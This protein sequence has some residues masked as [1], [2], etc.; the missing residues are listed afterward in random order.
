VAG[1]GGDL[2]V[3]AGDVVPDGV[4]DQVGHHLLDQQRVTVEGGGLDVGVDVE[5]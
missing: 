4:V 5:A 3:P 1:L 2:D